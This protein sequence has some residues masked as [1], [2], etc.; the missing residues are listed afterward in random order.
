MVEAGYGKQLLLSTDMARASYLRAYDGGPGLDYILTRFLPR[1]CQEGVAQE[2]ID[3][4]MIHNPA[5]A[6]A[7][8][9]V[10]SA[11]FPL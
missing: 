6:F 4:I 3:D 1:L 9:A 8:R 11:G 7:R 2:T 10:A 5:R